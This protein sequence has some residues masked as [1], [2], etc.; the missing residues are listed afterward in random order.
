MRAIIAFNNLGY[1]GVN[2]T[3]LWHSKDDFKHFKEK[4]LNQKLLV[5]YNT[6]TNLPPLKN[7]EIIL[8]ERHKFIVEGIDWCIGGKKTYEKYA[9]LFTEL[10]ISHIDNNSIGDTM[11][12]NLNSLKSDCKVFNYYFSETK[13]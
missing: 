6:F 13:L 1:I 9:H 11:F 10:H 8:D 12:P 3:M 7:R 4:T 5:G 2:N